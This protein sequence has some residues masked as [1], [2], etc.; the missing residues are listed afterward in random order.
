MGR[1]AAKLIFWMHQIARIAI[2]FAVV[3]LFLWLSPATSGSALDSAPLLSCD[4]NP[5]TAGFFR[6][7]WESDADRVEIQEGSSSDFRN[8]T[9][10]YVGP[11]RA[12]VISGKP[13]GTWFY[14]ARA[15]SG[16]RPGP[17]SKAIAVNVDHHSLSRAV[18]FLLLGIIVFISTASMIVRG[19]VN[20]E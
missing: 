6:L 16:S 7:R 15:V 18:L 2:Q 13:D 20:A 19:S 5:A 3:P 10:A 9:T 11:D 17:W 1:S 8:A 14:R 12:A 4:N